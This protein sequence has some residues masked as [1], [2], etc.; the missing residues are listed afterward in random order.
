MEKEK[1]QSKLDYHKNKVD[2]Y[3]Q[4]LKRIEEK[5]IL[6]VGFKRYDNTK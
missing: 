6:I 2:L 5:K 4:K 3:E 1:I